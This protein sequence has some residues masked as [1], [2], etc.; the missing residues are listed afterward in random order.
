MILAPDG[1][2]L[3][4]C[5][6]KKIQWYL[7]KNLAKLVKEEPLTAQLNFEP[8]GR[9]ISQYKGD[10]KK[11]NNYYV[12]Y[13]KDQCVVC[14]TQ[15]NYMRFQIVPA[16]Y[17]NFFPE[18][19]KS[20]RSHDIL[21]LCFDW[22]EI[23]IQKQYLLKRKLSEKYQVRSKLMDEDFIGREKLEVI[24]RKAKA[25]IKGNNKIPKQ[26][27]IE[28]FESIKEKSIEILEFN[29]LNEEDTQVIQDMIY[30]EIK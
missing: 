5:D 10:K 24:K 27:R 18:K 2:V 3:C 4:K 30:K 29:V 16:K 6:K 26:R 13:K 7:S 23:A 1:E 28:L 9:G 14:G 12:D 11:D 25:I 19:Y 8:N 21:L 15:D 17:R 20:H 22:N